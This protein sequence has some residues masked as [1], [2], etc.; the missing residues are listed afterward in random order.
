MSAAWS[1]GRSAARSTWSIQVVSR[2]AASD[3]IARG[4]RRCACR[5]S[6]AYQRPWF[7][8][9]NRRASAPHRAASRSTSP[10]ATTRGQ[11]ARSS[12]VTWVT[13]TN[14]SGWKTSLSVGATLR[15]PPTR[16]WSSAASHA[17][18]RA[19]QRVEERQLVLEV[20]VPDLAPVRHVH[21]GEPD[22]DRPVHDRGDQP[23]LTVEVLVAERARRLDVRHRVR[24]RRSPRRCTPRRRRARSCSRARR[25]PRAPRG[26]PSPPSS[27]GGR[28]RR[29]G[30]AR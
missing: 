6:R 19:A 8:H 18:T 28:S 17:S 23:R 16:T 13:P 22:L 11:R 29:G 2:R 3:V 7:H 27:P 5:G 30:P 1:L 10:A 15:S 25:A 26:R 9:V 4:A 20:P 24:A 12:G 21:A 14:A